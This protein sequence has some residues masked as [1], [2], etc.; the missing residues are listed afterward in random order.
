MSWRFDEEK[1]ELATGRYEYLLIPDAPMLYDEDTDLTECS[2]R[3]LG[4]NAN[5][6]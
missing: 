5:V 3:G 6:G 4:T 2:A 1:E